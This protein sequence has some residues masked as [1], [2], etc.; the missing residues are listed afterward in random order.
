MV[1]VTLRGTAQLFKLRFIFNV[2]PPPSQIFLNL[3]P[4]PETEQHLRPF[5]VRVPAHPSAPDEVC[6]HRAGEPDVHP[7]E[8]LGPIAAKFS[9]ASQPSLASWG[10][11][12]TKWD[13]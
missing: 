7:L 1:T 12:M 9:F 8:P 4:L 3:S 5:P 13:D 10:H 11:P 6:E 2:Y